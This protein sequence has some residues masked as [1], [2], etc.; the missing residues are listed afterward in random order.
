MSD[1]YAALRAALDAGPTPGPWKANTSNEIGPISKEDDQS[2]G[3]VLPV[4]FAEFENS[5]ANRRY[6]AAANPDTIR[7]L[8]ADYDRMRDAAHQMHALYPNVW[9]RA[10]GCLVVFPE[11]VERFDAAFEGLRAALAQEQ[12]GSDANGDR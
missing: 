3:M 6:I 4:C 11:N 10:D 2:F 1:R 7:A 9:D 5:E 12:G 8:L